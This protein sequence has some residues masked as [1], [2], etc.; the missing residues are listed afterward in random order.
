MV[1]WNLDERRREFLDFVTRI[2]ML[3][4]EHPVF[5]RRRYVRADTLTPEGLKEIIWLT[6]H[7]SEMTESDWQQGFARCLGVY[8]AGGAIERRGHRG[9]L[10]KDSNFLL[11]FN[12]HHETIPFRIAPELASKIWCTV[13]DTAED[14]AFAER[15]PPLEYP[16]Q[17]RSLVLL[18][19]LGTP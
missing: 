1:D 7:A 5:G 6:P 12:A 3:R 13:L 19:E 17:G 10:I 4:R 2:V 15:R 16:L 8:L 18:Q 9:Q 14:D 11:L